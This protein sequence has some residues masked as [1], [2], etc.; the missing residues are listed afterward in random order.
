MTHGHAGK[1]R[2][3]TYRSWDGMV[4]RT[5]NPGHVSFE[6][7]AGKVDELFLGPGGFERFLACVGKRPSRAYS[8]DRIDPTRGYEPGNIRW[9]TKKT[10][11]RNKVWRTFYGRTVAEWAALLG[12]RPTTV[13][14]RLERGWPHDRVFPKHLRA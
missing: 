8:L 11:A 10:Q 7:Y 2:S 12:I 5:T 14:K 3:P 4:Q 13:R 1:H 9:A 6:L